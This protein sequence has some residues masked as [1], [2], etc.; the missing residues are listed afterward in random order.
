MSNTV[1]VFFK[2]GRCSEIC[3]LDVTALFKRL[4]DRKPTITFSGKGLTLIAFKSDI[5]HVEVIHG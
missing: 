1:K 5:S 2:N 3:D 4:N